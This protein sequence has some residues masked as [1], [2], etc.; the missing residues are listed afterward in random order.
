VWIVIR[1]RTP[2]EKII[3]GVYGIFLGISAAIVGCLVLFGS[4]FSRTYR[5]GA[6]LLLLPGACTGVAIGIYDIDMGIRA[7]RAK[8]RQRAS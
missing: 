8:T 4:D 1:A 7:R 3:V 2:I 5:L 6:G